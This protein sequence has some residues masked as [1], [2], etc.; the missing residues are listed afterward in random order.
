[1]HEGNVTPSHLTE[2]ISL[3]KVQLVPEISGTAK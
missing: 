2:S 3:I 1:M